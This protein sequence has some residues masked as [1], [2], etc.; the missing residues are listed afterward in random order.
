MTEPYIKLNM[1]MAAELKL[2]GNELIAFAV[3][4]HYTGCA[5]G[6][7]QGMERLASWIGCARSKAYDAMASLSAK[8]LIKLSVPSKGRV[9]AVYVSLVN[10]SESGRLKSKEGDGYPSQIG[11]VNRPESGHYIE[12]IENIKNTPPIIPPKG[13]SANADAKPKQKRRGRPPRSQSYMQGERYPEDKL[14][15][16]GISLGE[17]FYDDT[18]E[19]MREELRT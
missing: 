7:S 12:N 19:S 10:R 14:R 17:E 15:R 8:G 3:V 18:I 11:T 5:G 16:M 1:W 2:S 13:G 4:H 6:Y 9:P